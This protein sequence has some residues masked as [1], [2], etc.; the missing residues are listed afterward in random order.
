[1]DFELCVFNH[2]LSSKGMFI[3]DTN[4]LAYYNLTGDS[5][6]LLQLKERGGRKN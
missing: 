3:K 4:S 1:L 2:L 6:I 5:T